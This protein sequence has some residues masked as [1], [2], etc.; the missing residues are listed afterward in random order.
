MSGDTSRPQTSV[1]RH[2]IFIYTRLKTPFVSRLLYS[3]I[4]CAKSGVLCVLAK[5]CCRLREGL[6][7]TGLHILAIE[8]GF[9]DMLKA[10][11]YFRYRH[12]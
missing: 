8:N 12:A 7:A 9:K 2:Y 10:H 11:N 5:D 3:T 1:L 6:R 4:I